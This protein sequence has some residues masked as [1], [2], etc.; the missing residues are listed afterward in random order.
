MT[1]G[2][3]GLRVTPGWT[4]QMVGSGTWRAHLTRRIECTLEGN[5]FPFGY[6]EPEFEDR[7][8]ESGEEH[9]LE[10]LK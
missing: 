7:S 8:V 3:R 4:T 5:I 2:R 10:T 9:Q 6:F 1:F